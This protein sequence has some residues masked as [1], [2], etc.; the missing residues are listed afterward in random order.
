V[1]ESAKS[2]DEW[3]SRN[4]P[5]FKTDEVVLAISTDVDKDTEK[6]KDHDC[7]DLK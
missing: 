6:D 5:V 4:I 7:G 2:A 3:R 1:G